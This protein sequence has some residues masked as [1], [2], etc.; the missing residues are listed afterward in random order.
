MRSTV[1]I[2]C[3]NCGN[4]HSVLRREVNRGG[5]KFCSRACSAKFNAKKAEPN[6]V[7]AYCKKAFH[8]SPSKVRNRS[9]SGIVF[10]CRDH[11]DLAQR[12]GGIK[13]IQPYHYG[14]GDGRYRYRKLALEGHGATC[15]RCGYSRYEGVLQVHHVNRNR[16]DNRLDNL[17]V[18]CPTCH[19]E[20]HFVSN[21]GSFTGRPLGRS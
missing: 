8:R 1:Q 9:K 19:V 13:E 11:K 3:L 2:E 10:C 20:E 16:S 4:E 14:S 21:D 17:E 7:C 12:V 5:G 15:A 18:L 6:F